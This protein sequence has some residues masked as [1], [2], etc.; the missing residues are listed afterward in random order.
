M[1]L[2]SNYFCAIEATISLIGGRYKCCI[3]WHIIESPL[4]YSELEKCMPHA[5][6]KMLS[7][8]LRELERDGFIIKHIYD[9]APVKK[10]EYS[11]SEMGRS[12]IPLL[13]LMRSWGQGYLDKINNTENTSIT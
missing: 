6:H 10:T 9:E 1:K 12:L 13:E 3:L 8:Q 7:Q 4:R 2:E 5:S 11:L